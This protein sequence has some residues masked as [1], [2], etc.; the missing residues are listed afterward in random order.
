V[1]RELVA[2]YR[3]AASKIELAMVND[4]WPARSVGLLADYTA[5]TQRVFGAELRPIDYADPARACKIIN[6][7]IS[8]ATRDRIKDLVTPDVIDASTPL[9]LT[10]AIYFK[11]AWQHPFEP[12]NTRDSRFTLTGGGKVPAKLMQQR[13]ELLYAEV[14]G[15]QV[16]RLPYVDANFVFEAALPAADQTLATANAALASGT[17]TDRLTATD[18]ELL[19]PRFRIEGAFR[20]KEALQALGLT[21][22]T[23]GAADFSGITTG[24]MFIDEVIHKTFIEVGE[25]GTE[26]AAATAVVMKR[27]SAAPRASKRF[28]ADRPFAFGIRDLRTGLLLFSGQLVAPPAPDAKPAVEGS[29]GR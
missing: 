15:L 21:L 22:S 27:G 26:A 16:V 13:R 28:V 20:L 10:N 11:A 17:F 4:L 14:D 25:E 3:T 23:T 19:L 9:V 6:D 2:N 18:L 12:E 7:H 24:R 8:K 1:V 29:T 5:T